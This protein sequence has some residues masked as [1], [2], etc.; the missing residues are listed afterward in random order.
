MPLV[1][2]IGMGMLREF[3]EDYRRSKSDVKFNNSKTHIF[4]DNDF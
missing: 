4:K 1:F 2:I 3:I